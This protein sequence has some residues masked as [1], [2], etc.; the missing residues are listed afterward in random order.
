MSKITQLAEALLSPS[1]LG[2]LV[3]LIVVISVPILLHAFLSRGSSVAAPPSILLVG[4]SGSGKTSLQTLFE[5][6]KSAPTHTSQTPL[7]AECALPVGITAASAKYRSANDPSHRVREKFLLIDTPGHGKLH[8]YAFSAVANTQNLK[9][10]IFVVDAAS[11]PAGDEGLRQAAEY[12]HDTLLLLQ[13]RLT[14][15]KS[16]K[17]P[18]GIEV[19]IAANKMDLFTAQPSAIVRSLL[20]KEIGKVRT[21]KSKGLLES[22]IE[23][24]GDLDD[25]DS[26]DWLGETGSTQFKF[27]QLEEFNISTE[28]AG[29]CAMGENETDVQKWWKWVGDRL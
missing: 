26:D 21:S 16:S 29:G 22:G 13:K 17:A 18:K 8:H 5:R 1:P 12:L 9:G 19:L 3:A 27:E 4:P 20:E 10:I 28:V 24:A 6:G 23:T 11:L 7:V 14:T 25:V 2:F 15:V